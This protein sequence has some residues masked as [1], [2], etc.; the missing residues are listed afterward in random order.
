M[1]ETFIEDRMLNR[2]Y[3]SDILCF[4]FLPVGWILGIVMK[5]NRISVIYVP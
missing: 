1:P 2:Q 3:L 5:I 4:Y